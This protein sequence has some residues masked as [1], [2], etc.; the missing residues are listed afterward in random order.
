MLAYFNGIY[1]N[2]EEISIPLSDRSIYFGD[3]VYDVCIA[4]NG[5]IYQFSEH[6]DRLKN[7]ANSL[8]LKCPEYDELFEICSI[9]IKDTN[10]ECM[11]YVQL[12]RN[13]QKRIHVYSDNSGTNLLVT[14]QELAISTE[15]KECSITVT[16]DLRH[17]FCNLKTVNLLPAVMAA[18]N[19]S[20]SGFEEVAFY[21]PD[22][23]VTEC[24]H[25]NIFI[26][27]DN[28][29][30]THPLNNKVLPGITRESIK[31]RSATCGL[32]FHEKPFTTEDLLNADEVFI[33]STTKF[34]KRVISIDGKNTK[35]NNPE[36]LTV[37]YN[38]LYSDFIEKATRN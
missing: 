27:F 30:Y 15:L 21:M 17:C 23:T 2:Y 20:L 33:S 34:I 5:A 9:I 37:L 26:L 24:S 10:S 32:E 31:L 11:V 6:Y 38:T 19:A 8:S 36:K 28:K 12:S 18:K 4:K 35:C 1:K 25:S 16:P 22:K 13:E 3:A 7:N 29:I 14:A